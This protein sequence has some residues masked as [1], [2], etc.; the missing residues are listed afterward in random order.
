MSTQLES[1]VSA[2]SEAVIVTVPAIIIELESTATGGRRAAFDI[3]KHE[4][5]GSPVTH[6][7]FS[8]HG[9]QTS[10]RFYLDGLVEQVG[11]QGSVA[12]LK[13]TVMRKLAERLSSDK[14][15][16]APGLEKLLT[17]AAQQGC[18]IGV[19]TSLPEDAAQVVFDRLGLGAKGAHLFPVI[20]HEEHFPGADVW[21][22]VAKGVGRASRHCIAV[23]DCQFSCKTALS[24]GMRCLVVPDEFTSYQDFGGADIVLDSWDD[25]S[26]K[27]ILASLTPSGV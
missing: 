16:L 22:K 17:T 15:S 12:A 3:I 9:A 20:G 25:M 7:V 8:R 19:V 1:H 2:K 23:V 6:A 26:A 4:L 11:S 10:P 13:D 24:A 18:K 5:G 27:E 21:L 14:V